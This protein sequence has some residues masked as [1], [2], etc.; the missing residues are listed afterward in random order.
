MAFRHIHDTQT[1]T[2]SH[3]KN[4]EAHTR[5]VGNKAVVVEVRSAVEIFSMLGDKWAVPVL[6]MVGAGPKRFNEIRRIIEN[7]SQRMLTRT[8]RR[9]ERDG[10]LEREILPTNPPGVVYSL[11]PLGVSLCPV[12]DAVAQWAIRNHGEIDAAQKRHDHSRRRASTGGNPGMV[13]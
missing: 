7:V 4:L 1:T 11:T 12:A 6:V 9:M 13:D 8:L 3:F 5:R 10:I 2:L